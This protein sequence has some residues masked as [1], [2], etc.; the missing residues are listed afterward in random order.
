MRQQL[1]AKKAELLKIQQQK[2]EMELREL[3]EATHRTSSL[4]K[5]SIIPIYNE[6][7]HGKTSKKLTKQYRLQISKS[8]ESVRGEIPSLNPSAS[9]MPSRDPRSKR[10][11]RTAR[12][13][14]LRDPRLQNKPPA[15]NAAGLPSISQVST[16]MMP[17]IPEP[18][19]IMSYSM[20]HQ[21]PMMASTLSDPSMMSQPA[22][23]FPQTVMSHPPP[24]MLHTSTLPY[25]V[26][27]SQF[28]SQPNIFNENTINEDLIAI[29]PHHTD[30]TQKER[31]IGHPK[32]SSEKGTLK[33]E[34]ERKAKE[35]ENESKLKSDGSH[36]QKAKESK[37]KE[38][39][40]KDSRSAES[41]RNR[42]SKEKSRDSRSSR[43]SSP[44]HDRGRNK[45]SRSR[46]DEKKKSHV[47]EEG[48]KAEVDRKRDSKTK[49]R[50]SKGRSEEDSDS[51]EPRRSKDKSPLLKDRSRSPI[52]RKNHSSKEKKSPKKCEGGEKIKEEAREEVTPEPAELEEKMDVEKNPGLS[53]YKIPK[54]EVIAEDNADLDERLQKTNGRDSKL[55][56]GNSKRDLSEIAENSGKIAEE[57][58]GPSKKPRLEDEPRLDNDL[59]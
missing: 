23:L 12:D 42:E 6:Y 25:L 41:G 55:V 54:K 45:D 33:S 58:E 32:Q 59:R 22:G 3:E 1:I 30:N 11:P 39:S 16:L 13:P 10:D 38:S 49:S 44:R 53:G 17:G 27:S 47:D 4:H 57:D 9:S 35:N 34:L 31:S 51:K 15:N 14:R 20:P 48:K 18:D 8:D 36:S 2:L 5:V 19:S 43:R 56:K 37:S 52:T 26:T 7:V 50:S 28:S 40:N 46:D 21:M 24:G 29:A